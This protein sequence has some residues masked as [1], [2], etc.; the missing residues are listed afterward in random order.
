[1]TDN[2]IELTDIAFTYPGAIRPSLQGVSLSIARGSCFGLLGPNGAGKTTLLSIL[3]G[4]LPLQQGRARIAGLELPDDTLKQR[5]AIVPQDYAFYMALSGRENLDC[6]AGLYGLNGAE[7]QR[8]IDFAVQVCALGPVLGQ[9]SAQYSGGVKRRLN[10]AIGLLNQPDILY[11]DE[12]T[13]GID[14]QSRHFILESIRD[15]QHSG[16]TIIYTSHYMEEVQSLCDAL[17]VIDHGQLLLTDTVANL[18]ERDAA[19]TARFTL[20]RSPG[21]ATLAALAALGSVHMDQ[22][23]LRME[24]ASPQSLETAQRILREHGISIRQ[25]HYGSNR[26]EDVYLS[27]TEHALRD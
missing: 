14:A 3:T 16:M 12:P 17:A 27:I 23:Q 11:L 1:M 6:F 21:D 8:R 26:L 9:P 22:Q 19:C 20:D 5:T 24:L 25:L 7:K 10:L 2:A 15:L 13:V 4:I 18:V